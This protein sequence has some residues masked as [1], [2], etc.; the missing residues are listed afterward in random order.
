MDASSIQSVLN[1]LRAMANVIR[2]QLRNY[3]YGPDVIYNVLAENNFLSGVFR[4]D[5]RNQKTCLIT[6]IDNCI[7]KNNNK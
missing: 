6:Y 5:F 1:A 4:R 2:G 3:D 7:R